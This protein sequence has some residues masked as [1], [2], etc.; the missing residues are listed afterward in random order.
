MIMTYK[1]RKYGKRGDYTHSQE[2]ETKVVAR[3]RRLEE[4]RDEKELK[5]MYDEMQQGFVESFES[6]ELVH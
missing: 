4:K 2:F 5:Q 1:K 6:G 3:H